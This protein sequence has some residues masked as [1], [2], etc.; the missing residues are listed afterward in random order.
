[1][2]LQLSDNIYDFF[3]FD[4][5]AKLLN[6]IAWRI[7]THFKLGKIQVTFFYERVSLQDVIRY[8]YHAV[9][10]LVEHT[11]CILHALQLRNLVTS[12]RRFKPYIKY[13]MDCL[14]FYG[15]TRDVK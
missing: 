11:L 14:E 1:M 8:V 13:L 4:K 7:V 3:F 12:L 10:E 6:G 15:N 5:T 9:S 2:I